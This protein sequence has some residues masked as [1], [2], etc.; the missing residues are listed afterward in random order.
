M[1]QGDTND[2]TKWTSMKTRSEIMRS[3]RVRNFLL[4]IRHPSWCPLCRIKE[5]NVLMTTILW[6]TDVISHGGNW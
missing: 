3:G 5:W 6:P 4:R 2:R 1:K